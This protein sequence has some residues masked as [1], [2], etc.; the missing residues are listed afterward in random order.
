MRGQRMILAAHQVKAVAAE[1][2]RTQL[3]RVGPDRGEREVGLPAA[4]AF[5]ACLLYTSDA[6]DE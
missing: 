2:L 1:R 4:N 3:G 6:A 5:D